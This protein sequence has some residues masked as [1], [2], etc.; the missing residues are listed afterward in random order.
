MRK[1]FAQ[2]KKGDIVTIAK[3]PDMKGAQDKKVAAIKSDKYGFAVKLEG[4]FTFRTSAVKAQFLTEFYDLRGKYL[5]V[6]KQSATK[7][8]EA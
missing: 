2:L 7:K 4:G 6:V 8:A 1:T 5:F 3:S